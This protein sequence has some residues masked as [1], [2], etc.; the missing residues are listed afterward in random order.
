M[1]LRRWLTPSELWLAMGFPSTATV[2]DAVGATC[3]FTAHS[4]APPKRSRASQLKQ[5][6]NCMHVQSLGSMMLLMLLKFYPLITKHRTA[7][8]AA[9][10]AAW[11]AQIIAPPAPSNLKRKAESIADSAAALPPVPEF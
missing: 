4:R 8:S 5:L 1:S 10:A 3:Q 6:G 7:A 9:A 2:A 11:A